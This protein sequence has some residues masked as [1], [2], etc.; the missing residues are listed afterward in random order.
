MAPLRGAEV[1][2]GERDALQGRRRR[3]RAEGACRAYGRAAVRR[4]PQGHGHHRPVREPGGRVGGNLYEKAGLAAISGSATAVDLTKGRPFTTFF[5]VNPN[6]AIQAPQIVAFVSENLKAKN[7]VV[8][9]SQDDYSLPLAGAISR[10]LRA[11]NVTVSRESVS[12][13]DTDFSS[14]VAN[15]GNERERGR[16]R[17]AG[18]V[19][20]EHALEPA[21]RAGQEGDRL[22]DRR[23]VLAVA[24]QAE[25][26]VRVG[27]RSGSALRPQGPRARPRVQPVLEEQA[28]RRLRPGDL[29]GR[30]RGDERHHEGVRQRP[31]DA[32]RGD[33]VRSPDEH[34]VDLRRHGS[35]LSK[36]GSAADEVQSSTRSRTASTAQVG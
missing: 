26:R 1:Q 23:R 25:D 10:G 14:I 32:S 27:L 9:D 28:V 2:Q 20:G 4:G 24:V 16:L 30:A 17:D 6:D 18:G 19:G 21:P 33:D 15:V 31:D 22:R 5:R 3:H 29:H 11:R 8:I 35:L 36:R 34:P 13:D 12:A 7:V